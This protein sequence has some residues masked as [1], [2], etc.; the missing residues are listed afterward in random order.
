MREL[1]IVL[2]RLLFGSQRLPNEV[3][4]AMAARYSER[5]FEPD[6]RFRLIQ[7]L[8]DIADP[9]GCSHPQ[10]DARLEMPG[11]TKP[12]DWIDGREPM[13]DLRDLDAVRFAFLKRLF[14]FEHARGTETFALEPEY[15]GRFA[16]K[17]AEAAQGD[18][19][20]VREIIEAI[21]LCY[22]PIPFPGVKERLC[23][24]IGHRYHEQPTRSYVA[25]QFIPASDFEIVVPRLPRRMCDTKGRA[26]LDY[27][28]DHFLLRHRG[29]GAR[30]LRVDFSLFSTLSDL[31]AGPAATSN[32]RPQREP[33]RCFFG[34]TAIHL[35][36]ARPGVHRLQHS[37]SIGES[38]SP[39]S[40]LEA[41]CG[42]E[43]K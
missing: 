5:L 36:A 34:T 39:L 32:A 42:G 2:A 13:P 33:A 37:A 21:N 10:W 16:E 22:C 15:A 1:W 11:G 3:P 26:A 29:A 24:W 17:L 12:A 23:L 40:G 35:P 28:P 43:G 27:Q 41:V 20:L 4:D 25:N 6:D 14:F 31:R 19:L 30:G 38:D 7:L 18:P 8:N 9:A